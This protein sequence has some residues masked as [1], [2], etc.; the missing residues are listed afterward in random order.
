MAIITL[1]TDL[2]LKD[3]YVAA[4]KGA[5]LKQLPEVTI[6]DISHLVPS[7]NIQQAAYILRNAY[8]N[9]PDGTVH[10]IGV[11]A[12]SSVQTPHLA[13][14]VA[15]QYFI[16]ADTGIF[17]FLFDRVPDRIVE[18]NIKQETDHLTFPVKDVFTIAA[19]HLA[20][21]GDLSFIGSPIERFTERT[22]FNPAIDSHSIRG[23]AMYID[24]YY[25]IVFNVSHVLF[26]EVGKGRPFTIYFRNAA[27]SSISKRYGDVAEGEVL[28]LFNSAGFLE[29]AQ[30]LGR[31]GKSESIQLNEMITIQFE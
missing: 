25:N 24:S 22:Y 28:A 27:I 6:V 4:V 21:G 19:C 20:R 14:Q 17:S 30:N 18:L 1:T 2:G 29:I 7:F 10:I 15:G 11:N 16:G 23:N 9:F 13:M 8:P 3:H 5:I 26:K 31:L 12:E